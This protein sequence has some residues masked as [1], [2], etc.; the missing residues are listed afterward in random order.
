MDNQERILELIE[1]LELLPH[2]EGGFYKEIYRS[3]D[4]L[5]TERGMRNLCTS[6]YFLLPSDKVSKFH[7]IKSDELWFFHEGSPLTIHVLDDK[8]Y[9]K[10]ILGPINQPYCHPQ[11]LVRAGLIFGST[12]NQSNSY[13][14][15]SCVVAP[16]FDFQ[17]FELFTSA[18]LVKRFPDEEDIIVQLT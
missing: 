12:V 13:S 16:G 11:Q 4:K 3:M 15:V 10:L 9:S 7:R 5:G 14:L 8:E 1:K 6:I 18:D 17:D 2:P